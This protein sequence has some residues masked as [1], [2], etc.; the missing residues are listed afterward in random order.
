VLTTDHLATQAGKE[1]LEIT[2]RISLDGKFDA[3]EIKELY[4]W[5]VANK[6][7]SDVPAIA[8]LLDIINRVA[9]DKRIDRDELMELHLAELKFII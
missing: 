4:R 1:L 9:A 6:S 8:Y 7:T 2:V 3:D 5:L